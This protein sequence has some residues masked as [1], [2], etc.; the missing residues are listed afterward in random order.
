MESPKLTKKTL[1]E[2]KKEQEHS[3][4]KERTK[5]PNRWDFTPITPK[6]VEATNKQTTYEERF[7]GKPRK[8]IFLDIDG[9]MN[10][11]KGTGPYLADMEE[12]KLALL[13]KVMDEELIYGII[14][15]S[16]RRYSEVYMKH[17]EDALDKYEIFMIDTIRNPLNIFEDD[18]D[19]KGRQI[20]DYL[21]IATDID[22]FVILDDMDYGVSNLFPNEYIKVNRFYG[23]NDDICRLIKEKLEN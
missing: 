11:S 16:D 15:T 4:E 18:D 8:V 9:V 20:K 13:K 19:S 12:S 2:T 17:F 1:N 3:L 21:Q 14:L 10:S 6:M 22:K 5:H 23:L 7:F